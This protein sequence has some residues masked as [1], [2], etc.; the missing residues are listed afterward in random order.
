[1]KKIS[2]K[3]L[4]ITGVVGVS[5]ISIPVWGQAIGKLISPDPVY[6]SSQNDVAEHVITV[7]GRGEMTV[8][9]DVAFISFGIQTQA[10]NANDAQTAN[11]KAFEKLEKV[12]YEQYKIDK[13]DVKTSGF[14]VQPEYQY[15][16]KEKPK[17]T[18]Y[19][20]NHT[21][22]VTYRNLPKLGELLD[23]VSV[24]GANRIDN[25]Q[26]STEKGQDYELQMLE[27]A[28]ANAEAKAKVLAKY[29]G[30]PL[31]GIVNITQ[32]SGSGTPII[33]A[34]YDMMNVRAEASAASTSISGGQLTVS[35]NVNVQFEF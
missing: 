28:M 24:A 8:E 32:T 23:D 31:K 13:K 34:N 35:A 7:T 12:L 33:Y 10:D 4:L 11:A 2:M 1:M 18:G 26:F 20:A 14:Q 21:L 16:D 22:Q 6:A 19:T 3:S 30:K 15:Y 27:K 17:I 9:P 29:A 25:I 5:L